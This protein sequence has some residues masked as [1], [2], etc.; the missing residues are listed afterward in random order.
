MKLI[1]MLR[2]MKEQRLKMVR[3]AMVMVIKITTI[4]ITMINFGTD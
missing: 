3:G 4:P 2:K 1:R